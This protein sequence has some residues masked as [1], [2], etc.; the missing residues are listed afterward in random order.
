MIATDRVVAGGLDRHLTGRRA[1]L[2]RDVLVCADAGRVVI[3]LGILA[4]GA[5]AFTVVAAI[6]PMQEHEALQPVNATER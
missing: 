2:P 6:L 1:R 5:L 3:V 4:F